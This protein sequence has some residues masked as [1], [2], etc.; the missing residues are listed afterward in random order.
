M[1][2]KKAFQLASQC[3]MRLS[4]YGTGVVIRQ[5]PE[6]G[7]RGV[8]GQVIEVTLGAPEVRE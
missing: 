3:G 8:A 4:V 5:N 7:T 6:P 1:G 2:L